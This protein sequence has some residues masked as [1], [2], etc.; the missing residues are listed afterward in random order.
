MRKSISIALAL[1]H[2]IVVAN[3]FT[4]G[5]GTR[6]PS[7]VSYTPITRFSTLRKQHLSANFYLIFRNVFYL[8]NLL[9]L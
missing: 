7:A 2:A 1:I 3:A 5:L 6:N 9:I 4:A 8:L